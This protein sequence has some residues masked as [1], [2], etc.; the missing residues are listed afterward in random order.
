MSWQLSEQRW[1]GAVLAAGP[2]AWVSAR[3]ARFAGAGAARPW[4]SLC[5]ADA[6]HRLSSVSSALQWREAS[7]PSGATQPNLSPGSSVLPEATL[8]SASWSPRSHIYGPFQTHLYFTEAR[9]DFV[10][11]SLVDTQRDPSV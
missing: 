3:T 4:P 1:K 11:I 5:L 2:V 8:L 10:T 9:A 6:F 7:L